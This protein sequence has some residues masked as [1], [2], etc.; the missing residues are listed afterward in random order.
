MYL[1]FVS[2][3]V[4]FTQST[5]NLSLFIYLF[6]FRQRGAIGE[7]R[8]AIG[9]TRSEYPRAPLSRRAI[10]ASVYPKCI[11]NYIPARQGPHGKAARDGDSCSSNGAFEGGP[12]RGGSRCLGHDGHACVSL[13]ESACVTENVSHD[14]EGRGG[15][16]GGGLLGVRSP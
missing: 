2:R 11:S 10:G 16:R 5:L 3:R 13:R 14:I 15:G 1:H 8:D 9:K 4:L 6:F 12:L 7:R